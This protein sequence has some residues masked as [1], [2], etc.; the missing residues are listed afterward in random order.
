MIGICRLI[1]SMTNFY[2]IGTVNLDKNGPR[3]LKRMLA[4]FDPSVVAV[5]IDPARAQT[6]DK[7]R[8]KLSNSSTLEKAIRKVRKLFPGSDPQTISHYL[9]NDGFE[10]GCARDFCKERGLRDVVLTDTNESMDVFCDALK[11]EESPQHQR[12]AGYLG[13]SPYTLRRHVDNMYSGKLPG[14][15]DKELRA[16]PQQHRMKARDTRAIELLLRLDDPEIET[17][18]H[19][20]SLAHVFGGQEYYRGDPNLF[21]RFK[22]KYKG[23]GNVE[24]FRL[25]IAD[26][27][28]A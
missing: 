5:Q 18:V 10:Y 13:N 9:L 20:G 7:D 15:T 2:F 3:R 6:Y 25:H 26:Q 1:R 21:D 24:R 11:D 16:T 8:K 19:V 22:R 17:V 4:H 28:T 23:D 27:W 14:L 12:L